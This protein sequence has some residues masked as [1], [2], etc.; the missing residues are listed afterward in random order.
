[1]SIAVGSTV[2]AVQTPAV[3]PRTR[4]LLE[5]SIMPTLLRLA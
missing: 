2:P 1:M 3:D 4:L 5:G